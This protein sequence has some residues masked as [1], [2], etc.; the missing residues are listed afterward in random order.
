[1]KIAIN[2]AMY[3]INKLLKLSISSYE[4]DKTAKYPRNAHT[5]LIRV[6]SG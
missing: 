4:K 6:F 2:P 3:E 1:M 5:I